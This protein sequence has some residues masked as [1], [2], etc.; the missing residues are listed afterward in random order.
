MTTVADL[1]AKLGFQVDTRGFDNFKKSLEAFQNIVRDGLKDLK[2]YARQAERIS[3]AFKEA[4]LPSKQDADKR[5][6][7][8]IYAMRAKAYAQRVRAKYL[9]ETLAVRRYNASIRDRQTT[10]KEA[11]LSGAGRGSNGALLSILGMLS[12]GIGGVISGGLTALGSA[13]GGPVG[14]A[15]GIA[16]SKLMGSV[17]RGI[18][19]VGRIIVNQMKQAI[20]YVMAFR[21]YRAFTGRSHQGLRGLMGMTKYST[22]LGPEDVMKDAAAM[23]REYWDMWFGGGN[24]AIWQLLGVMPTMSGEANLKNMLGAIYQ[25]TGGLKNRGLALSLLKQAGLSE[26]YMNILDRWETYRK[27][28]GEGSFFDYSQEQIKK[29]EDANVALREFEFALN[30]ARNEIVKVLLDAGLKEALQTIVSWVKGFAKALKEEGF[31]GAVTNPRRNVHYGETG[32]WMSG[33]QYELATKK[34]WWAPGKS[35]FDLGGPLAYAGR[36]GYDSLTRLF[37][38]DLITKAMET[39]V[40]GERAMAKGLFSG[41]TI[42]N[43]NNSIDMSGRDVSDGVE[44]ISSLNEKQGQ[45]S[46]DSATIT[47]SF[48][49][50]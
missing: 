5:Y 33:R 7:A 6:R 39:T 35:W 18:L 26:D 41:T 20:Q 11:G 40:G 32:Q 43:Y 9:P 37:S 2:E 16:I 19:A 47:T 49:A 30:D 44:A 48:N 36:V 42:N 34:N 21:D 29:M 45:S 27:S 14:A 10:L 8:E 22:N 17:L 4:Y 46:L 38:D 3:K 12:G 15:V 23:G 28:G 31:W 24:P 1:V 13:I 50:G 25:H